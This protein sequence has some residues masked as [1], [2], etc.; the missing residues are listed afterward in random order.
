MNELI[1]YLPFPP[2]VNDYYGTRKAGKRYIKYIKAAGKVF[3]EEA[4][5]SLHRQLGNKGS[6]P[7]TDKLMVE[8]TLFMPDRRGRDMDNYNKALLDACSADEKDDWYGLWE[9]DKQLD[10][11]FMYRGAVTKGGL[12]MLTVNLAGPVMPLPGNID[13]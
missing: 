5:K 8:A 10:Q 2:S 11:L 4:R 1:L 6:Y 12:V 7:L 9:N 13:L 3:R